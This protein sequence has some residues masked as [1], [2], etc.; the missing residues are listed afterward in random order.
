MKRISVNVGIKIL[1]CVLLLHYLLFFLPSILL[2]R[3][4]KGKMASHG[5]IC[6]ND[7]NT[8]Y[9][10]FIENMPDLYRVALSNSSRLKEA[11]F[12]SLSFEIKCLDTR[13]NLL[14]KKIVFGDEVV[15][16]NYQAG[17]PY[18]FSIFA[19]DEIIPYGTSW[20]LQLHVK[21]PMHN[22]TSNPCEYMLRSYYIY[23]KP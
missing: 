22:Q 17:S 9:N 20:I 14:L 4:P 13:G 18:I 10:I 11:E 23:G 21:K 7:T 3:R 6:L 8:V 19:D 5:M 15:R 2:G 1:L 12:K 16:L